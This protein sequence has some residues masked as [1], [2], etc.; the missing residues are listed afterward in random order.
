LKE[1]FALESFFF[2]GL[3]FRVFV[4]S[5]FDLI[6]VF[7]SVILGFE[8]RQASSLKH[9]RAIHQ[10]Q[11]ADSREVCFFMSSCDFVARPDKDCREIVEGFFSQI[12]HNGG[13]AGWRR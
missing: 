7:S 9:G 4:F 8:L 11:V 2:L 1:S 3:G 12:L 13:I 5:R 10:Q 6:F